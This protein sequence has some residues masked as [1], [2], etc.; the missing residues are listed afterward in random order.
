MDEK[1]Y[2]IVILICISI[3]I[4]ISDVEHLFMCLLAF[5][6]LW[7]NIYSNHLPIF[8]FVL[9]TPVASSSSLAKNGT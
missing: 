7:R 4:M 8:V 1:L 5:L 3:S 2:L 9:A 6:Y